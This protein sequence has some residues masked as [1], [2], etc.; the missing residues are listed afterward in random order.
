MKLLEVK[1]SSRAEKKWAAVFDNDGRKK[2]IH[3]G[4]SGYHDF[5]TFSK[6]ERDSHKERYIN[7]HSKRENWDN[8]QTPGSLSRWI[9]WNKPT[10]K[11]SI[12][13]YKKKFDL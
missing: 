4:S 7:R 1:P 5:T 8:P 13:D 3:F 10:M 6:E 12:A 2:T 11:A 9:L